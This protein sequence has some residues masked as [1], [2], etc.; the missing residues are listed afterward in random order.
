MMLTMPVQA[1]DSVTAV[2]TT[3]L[4][5]RAYPNKTAKIIDVLPKGAVVEAYDS[6]CSDWNK[7]KFPDYVGYVYNAYLE[8]E[9]DPVPL[10]A[11]ADSGMS[12]EKEIEQ[13]EKVYSIADFQ[14]L[15]VI[16]WSGWNWTYYLMRQYPGSTSTSCP[17]RWVN[18]EG[19]V[20]DPDG[21]VI[22]AS[23]DLA[24]YTEVETPFG[25]MGKVYDTG[26]ASGVL[27]VYTD[28]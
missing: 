6:G 18:D 25:Y 21:F 5:V 27:D 9:D 26:C 23:A 2:V 28:W 22:L 14:W 4:N 24:P 8:G 7:I 16:S 3:D 17:G 11:R 20:C 19:F 1:A 10:S 15:G 13:P 12:P